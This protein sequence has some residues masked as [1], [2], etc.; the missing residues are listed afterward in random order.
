MGAVICG[1]GAAFGHPSVRRTFL[2][3]EPPHRVAFM[4]GAF[5]RWLGSGAIIPLNLGHEDARTIAHGRTG[6]L[7]LWTDD[8]GL[9]FRAKLWPSPLADAVEQRMVRGELRGAS[10]EFLSHGGTWSGAGD[11]LI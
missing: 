11:D 8:F 10:I 6:S 7:T 1:Y 3:N 9:A 4:R 2:P 5:D